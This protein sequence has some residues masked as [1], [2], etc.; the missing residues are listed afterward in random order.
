MKCPLLILLAFVFVTSCIQTSSDKTD[1]VIDIADPVSQQIFNYKNDRNSKEIIPFLSVA[2]PNRRLAAVKAF[3]SL[4]DTFYIS[5]LARSLQDPVEKIRQNAAY[6]LGQMKHPK[7]VPFLLS[8]FST[9]SSDLVKSTILEAIGKTGSVKEL[10]DL[11]SASNYAE[12][13]TLLR[14]GLTKAIY[15]FSLRNI[16]HRLGTEKIILDILKN[17]STD[18][19]IAFFAS[20]YLERRN[21]QSL[22]SYSKRLEKLIQS[23]SNPFILGNYCTALAKASSP[24]SIQIQKQQFALHSSHQVRC[25]IIN[26]LMYYPRDSV[27]EFVFSALSDSSIYV[28]ECAAQYL[29]FN[30]PFSHY[31]TALAAAEFSSSIKIRSLLL[32]A[33]LKSI[34]EYRHGLKSLL[35]AQIKSR[36][37]KTLSVYEK[38]FL[39]DALSVYNGNA[40]LLMKLYSTFD[41]PVLQSA[42]IQSCIRLLNL[43]A[44]KKNK[45]KFRSIFSFLFNTLQNGSAAEKAIIGLYI[46]ENE[47]PLRSYY[48]LE[49]AIQRSLDSLSLP[50]D[51]ETYYIL[52]DVQSTIFGDTVIKPISEVYTDIDWPVLNAMPD[53]EQITIIINEKPYL[54]DLLKSVAP[55]TITQFIN[56]IKSNYYTNKYIHRVVPNF[57]VQGGC[58]RGDGWSGIG[59]TIPSEFDSETHYDDAFYLGMASA[60][61]DTESAQF[62]ITSSPTPHLDGRYTIFGK[63]SRNYENIYNIRVGDKIDAIKL[64]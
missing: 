38:V 21:I 41:E 23:T 15:R 45:Q 39:L 40:T 5:E 20:A 54:F 12:N 44:S 7:V 43:P 17:E 8:A 57:V 26:S 10:I 34:P 56:L 27:I 63:S 18:E 61:K 36:L 1:P 3:A 30:L 28:Q 31:E 24:S 11:C 13:N 58:I 50:N 51:I 37:E 35:S 32:E 29:R 6:S 62:F 47:S 9:D 48:G 55:A 59:I 49:K 19:S 2:N 64:N 53:K 22:S 52:Q 16:I 46:T 42:T 33:A 14:L 60:G 25:K 4:Q